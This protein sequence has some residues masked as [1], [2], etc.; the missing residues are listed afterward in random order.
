LIGITVKAVGDLSCHNNLLTS[1]EGCL[2]VEGG[3]V[4][5]C[6]NEISTLEHYRLEDGNLSC[7]NNKLHV[8]SKNAFIPCERRTSIFLKYQNY[9]DVWIISLI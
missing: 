4:D 7:L 1:L 9:Y 8:L 5:C 6:R 2:R 3:G